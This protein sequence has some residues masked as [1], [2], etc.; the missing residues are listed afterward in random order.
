[1]RSFAVALSRALLAVAPFLRSRRSRGCVLLGVALLSSAPARAQAPLSTTEGR[2]TARYYPNESRLAHSLLALATS[3]DTFPGLRR[4]RQH[5]T[6]DIA[7]DERSFRAWIGPGAPEWGAAIAFPEQ[8]RIVMQGRS[9]GSDAGDPREV[10][11]H[12]LAHLALHETL[13]DLPPRWFDEGYASY[14][15]R[16][17]T[18]DDALAAN[19]VLALRG[20]PSLDELDEGFSGSTQTVQASY[21]LSYRAVV[22][23]AQLDPV[24]GLSLFFENWKRT[25]R[26]DPAIRATYGLTLTEFEQ[27]WQQRTRR[28]YGA[29]ALVSDFTLATIVVGFLLGPLYLARRRR[30]R[31]RMQVLVAADAAA[32]AAARDRAEQLG[33]EG[34]ALEELLRPSV[35]LPLEGQRREPAE[36]AMAADK[37]THDPDRNGTADD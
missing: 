29:L 26:I 7:P 23:L 25:G 31:R 6:L 27:R 18:R 8:H 35:N 28:R 33:V 10:M 32:D 21:A 3:N 22:E 17:L 20:V 13:G 15:A 14:A 5:V 2:I 4:P 24:H 9:A 1:L 19:V 37:K 11:R 34:N 12:E 30:D 16:E 36:G